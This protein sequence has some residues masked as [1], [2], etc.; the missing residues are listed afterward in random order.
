MSRNKKDGGEP[1]L[2][3]SSEARGVHERVR[4]ADASHSFLLC[5]S[6][7]GIREA[8]ARVHAASRAYQRLGF[9]SNT[10][11]EDVERNASLIDLLTQSERDINL[12]PKREI[13]IGDFQRN[14]KSLQHNG[15]HKL[16]F[17]YLA[18]NHSSF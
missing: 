11:K 13:S 2:R 10:R 7:H 18:K 9:C 3:I 4:K 6:S 14:R 1:A 16:L 8:N 15:A 5:L 12:E 17:V